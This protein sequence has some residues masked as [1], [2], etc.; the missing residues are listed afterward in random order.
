MENVLMIEAIIGLAMFG[1]VLGGGLLMFLHSWLVEKRNEKQMATL[2]TQV[3]PELEEMTN[4]MMK[5]VMDITKTSMVDMMKEVNK[6]MC[7]GD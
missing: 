4:R 3:L 1:L 7:D 2:K 5:N 6:S